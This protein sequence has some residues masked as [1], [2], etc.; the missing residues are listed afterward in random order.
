[1]L[2]KEPFWAKG[3]FLELRAFVTGL[4]AIH[5]RPPDLARSHI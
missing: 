3:S 2:R 1:M 5:T 4:A